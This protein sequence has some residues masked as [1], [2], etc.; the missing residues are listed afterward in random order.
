MVDPQF[1]NCLWKKK[2]GRRCPIKN[3]K[4]S[5]FSLVRNTV[6]LLKTKTNIRDLGSFQLS[7]HHY[8]GWEWSAGTRIVLPGNRGR[9]GDWVCWV[10]RCRMTG[11]ETTLTTSLCQREKENILGLEICRVCPRFQNRSFSV[12]H[13]FYVGLPKQSQHLEQVKWALSQEKVVC[14]N[15]S[16]TDEGVYFF[17]PFPFTFRVDVDWDECQPVEDLG[18]ISSDVNAAQRVH[19]IQARNRHH[20]HI[21][22]AVIHRANTSP[23]SRPVLWCAGLGWDSVSWTVCLTRQGNLVQSTHTYAYA[24]KG[25]Y[26][27]LGIHGKGGGWSLGSEVS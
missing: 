10:S 4:R 5:L 27:L 25:L 2:N 24:G 3:S 19:T 11:V 15:T 18:T 20:Y 7:Y 12:V 1:L 21:Y 13:V 8:E 6:P 16:R 22:L 14:A 23:F 26:M 9:F 17:S